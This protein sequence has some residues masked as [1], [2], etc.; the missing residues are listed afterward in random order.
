MEFF[1]NRIIVNG[2]KKSFADIVSEVTNR[3]MKKK[4]SIVKQKKNKK[5]GT[6]KVAF[7]KKISKSSKDNAELELELDVVEDTDDVV[8]DTDDVVE[9]TDDV[10]IDDES[11]DDESEDEELE[12]DESEDEELEDDESEDEELEDEESEDEEL[13]DEESEDEESEDEESDSNSDLALL[14]S[15]EKEMGL[16]KY[17]KEVCSPCSSDVK[18]ASSIQF[19]KIANLT[20]RQKSVFRTYWSNIWPKSFI[21]AVLDTEN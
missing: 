17:S 16:G 4:A 8:E 18:S 19:V 2:P 7:I 21:D 20:D 12:D 13:E 6:K 1:T 10:D 9:D 15:F 3:G 11:E 14:E 5:L